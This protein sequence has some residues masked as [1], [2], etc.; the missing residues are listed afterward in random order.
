MKS[1]KTENTTRFET[2]CEAYRYL[3]YLGGRR[4]NLK[5]IV[6][7]E[8]S[9]T[10][11]IF[12]DMLLQFYG[13]YN[14][15]YSFDGYPKNIVTKL[16]SCP[17]KKYFYG[18]N[19]LN[20]EGLVYLHTLL[21]SEPEKVEER[22]EKLFHDVRLETLN[23]EKI[24]YAKIFNKR[25]QPILLG[26]QPAV[27]KRFYS[28]L[29]RF[30]N[31]IY[32]FN[33]PEFSKNME[34]FMEKVEFHAFSFDKNIRFEW[35]FKLEDN[36]KV[37]V[38][39]YQNESDIYAHFNIEKGID[40]IESLEYRF[41]NGEESIRYLPMENGD[42]ITIRMENNLLYRRDNVYLAKDE[43]YEMI[44]KKLS[45]YNQSFITLFKYLEPQNEDINTRCR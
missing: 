2:A 32:P 17:F 37:N 36:K 42:A 31:I 26:L 33:N 24:N 3:E 38:E 4:V 40:T 15:L 9:S 29:K 12:D 35:S 30:L 45:F 13:E 5:S 39:Y 16:E 18:K 6:P 43:D 21:T 41:N 22:Y 23:D 11:Y 14:S 8:Q 27:I 19:I 7:N 25:R 34:N 28:N 20:L 44:T 10:A 1:K